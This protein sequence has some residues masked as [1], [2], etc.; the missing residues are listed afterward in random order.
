MKTLHESNNLIILPILKPIKLSK[1]FINKLGG[2]LLS[3]VVLIVALEEHNVY[4]L[5][6]FKASNEN[7]ENQEFIQINIHEGVKENGELDIIKLTSTVSLDNIYKININDFKNYLENDYETLPYLGIKDQINI[8]TKLT[9]KFEENNQPKLIFIKKRKI[10]KTN[11]N[12]KS[13][14]I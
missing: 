5:S 2:K 14:N 6:C 8:I 11:Q 12:I 1:K 3:N 4:F 13:E 7:E 10:E 9:N